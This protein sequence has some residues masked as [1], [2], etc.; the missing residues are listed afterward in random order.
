MTGFTDDQIERIV[1]KAADAAA[2]KAVSRI[3]D[4][5][6]SSGFSI[7]TEGARRERRELMQY[8]AESKAADDLKKRERSKGVI[9]ALFS[10][11]TTIVLGVLAWLFSR[12]PPYG[13]HAP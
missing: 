12:F 2:A 13:G 1:A 3:S 8:V 5:L 10:A 9:V 6:E 7:S 4:L 11:G